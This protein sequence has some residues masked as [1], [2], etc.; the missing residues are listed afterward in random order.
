[1]TGFLESAGIYAIILFGVLE[2]M[3]IPI[4]SELTF[5]LGGALAGGALGAGHAHPSL[6]LVIIAGTIAELVGSYIAYGVGRA[7]GHPLVR[8]Y[9]RY[10]LITEADV[11]RA[12]RFLAGRGAWALPVARM[13]PFI[14]A[15][16]S[17]V[18]GLVDIPP[19]R[20]GILNLIGT[21][22]YIIALSSIGYSLGHQ[23]S[24]VSHDI[25]DVGYV[26]GAIIVIA[27]IGFVVHRLREFR[28]EAATA[29]GDGPGGRSGG[30]HA[31]GERL[32]R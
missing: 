4:S 21:V 11:A 5:L 30:R 15:F 10:V 20:F 24:K 2:A 31:S 8:R 27:I 25:G 12:E 18:A 26:L 19:V 14:R 17:I 1:M 13:L 7:G 22:I 9:G 28:K 16:A 32:G 3:C 6:L 29:G 23:W